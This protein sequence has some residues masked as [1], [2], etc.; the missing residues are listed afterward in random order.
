L[1][2]GRGGDALRRQS[3]GRVVGG[4]A[5]RRVYGERDDDILPTRATWTREKRGSRTS[6]A[7][8]REAISPRLGGRARL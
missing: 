4:A 6:P 3:G 1:A 2:A 8:Q 7:P 5:N